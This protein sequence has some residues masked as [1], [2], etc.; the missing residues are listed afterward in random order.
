MSAHQGKRSKPH[1]HLCLWVNTTTRFS[2]HGHVR[3]CTLFMFGGVGGRDGGH[4]FFMCL[5]Q[6]R[7]GYKLFDIYKRSG[8]FLDSCAIFNIMQH[9]V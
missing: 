6:G 7:W 9:G 4:R 3:G 5:D 1:L 2:T 8:N